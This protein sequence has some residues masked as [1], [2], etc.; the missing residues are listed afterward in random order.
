MNESQLEKNNS[1]TFSL[2][3]KLNS[4][5][6]KEKEPEKID[7]NS[8]YEKEKP[9]KTRLYLTISIGLYLSY[10][11]P[12]YWSGVASKKFSDQSGT[13]TLLS[14]LSIF[15]KALACVFYDWLRRVF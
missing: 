8:L 2:C 3:E 14:E 1:S 9:S 13:V 11:M 7:V 10:Y 5:L 6:E 15:L 4:K 12:F